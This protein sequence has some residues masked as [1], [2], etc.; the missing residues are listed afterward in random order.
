MASR[1]EK[2]ARERAKELWTPNGKTAKRNR[3]KIL[4]ATDVNYLHWIRKTANDAQILELR[5]EV[6][7]WRQNQPI[8]EHNAH[9]HELMKREAKLAL[10]LAA[11]LVLRMAQSSESPGFAEA[12]E[13]VTNE[14][15][16]DMAGWEFK[17]DANADDTG[18][19]LSMMRRGE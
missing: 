3:R 1:G 10:T 14:D 5:D 18:W 17:V 11:V 8:I 12:H 13:E 16:E 15:V 6:R 19:I 4:E 7:F 2:K 9:Q